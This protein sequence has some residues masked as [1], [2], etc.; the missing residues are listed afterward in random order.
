MRCNH[1]EKSVRYT[2]C[3]LKNLKN[4]VLAILVN[5]NRLTLSAGFI[6]MRRHASEHQ[7]ANCIVSLR[8]H[9]SKSLRFLRFFEITFNMKFFIVSFNSFYLYL[10]KNILVEFVKPK[11]YLL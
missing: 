10:S 7:S 2:L 9:N 6:S 4:N 5:I 11:M 3:R 8:K 1:G